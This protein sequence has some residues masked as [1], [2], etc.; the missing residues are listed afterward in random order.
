VYSRGPFGKKVNDWVIPVDPAQSAEGAPL[1]KADESHW[2]GYIKRLEKLNALVLK[3]Q[4][5]HG[6]LTQKLK[7]ISG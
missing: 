7:A 1:A 4:A 5:L 6:E 2:V 3:A